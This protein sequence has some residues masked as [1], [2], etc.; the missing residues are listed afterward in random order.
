MPI[1]TK[2]G[3]KGGTKLPYDKRNRSKSDCRVQSLGEIDELNSLI[4]AVIAFSD[5]KRINALLSRVQHDLFR[6]QLDIA[7]KGEIFRDKKINPISADN[8]AWLEQ[9]IDALSKKLPELSMFIVPG[10]SKAGSLSQFARAVCRRAERELSGLNKKEP[11]NPQAL[12][13]I[14]RL[15]DFLF[16]I[17]RFINHQEH[18]K[19]NYPDYYKNNK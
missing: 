18:F 5:K 3:D 12:A 4:G 17:A 14:N 10:G 7:S 19:E 15:S 9:Q 1:Y 11:V 16:T 13:Y 2:K 8:I 6:V